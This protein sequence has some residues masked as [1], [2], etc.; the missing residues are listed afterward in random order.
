M[1][2]SLTLLIAAGLFVRT[3]RNLAST[4][5]GLARENLVLMTVDPSPSKS[6]Q[7]RRK[8]WRQLA[9]RLAPLP[10]VLSVSLGGDAVFGNGGWNDGIWVRQPDGTEHHSQ[11]AFNLVGPGFFY[12]VGI[13]LLTG[14]E[15]GALDQENSSPVAVVNRAFARKFFGEDNPVGKRFGAAGAGSSRQIEIVGVIA[16]AKYG[17]LRE[18]PRPMFYLPFFQ[19]FEDV[20]YN[21]H[22]RMIG[23]PAAVIAAMRREIQSMDP[24]ISVYGV[25]TI[26]E[27]IDRLLQPDRMFAVLAS[28]FGLLALLL[29]SIGIYGVVAYQITR[30]TGEVGIRM[31]LGAQRRDVLWMFMR[32]TLL[33]VAVGAAIGLP[34]A[35]A[36]AYALRSLLFGLEPSDP[37][38]IVGAIVTLAGAGALAGFLPARRAASLL[39]MDALRHE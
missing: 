18:Q 16:D 39:P 38:T 20:P 32:E 22:A 26:N 14:R 4:D 21:V 11:A 23:N 34:A 27:V 17:G 3:L 13:P 29:T 10:G 15:F 6:I 25:R 30:R 7:D 8:F 5:L 2:L 24:D 9:E 1:A 35:V 33:V 37:V 28:V 19:H 12:T 31:A 36:A